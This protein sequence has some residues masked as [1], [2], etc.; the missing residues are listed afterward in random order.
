MFDTAPQTRIWCAGTGQ[1]TSPKRVEPHHPSVETPGDPKHSIGTAS[2]YIHLLD[3]IVVCIGHPQRALNNNNS[4]LT[5][6]F[7]PE[8][9]PPIHPSR[10]TKTQRLMGSFVVILT[11][12][13]LKMYGK[14]L[15]NQNMTTQITYQYLIPIH[16]HCEN[17]QK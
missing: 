9:Y 13:S 6:K 5:L 14:C 11:S 15:G 7:Y 10:E 17:S 1:V 2:C 3:P 12:L 8:C 4:F 16:N